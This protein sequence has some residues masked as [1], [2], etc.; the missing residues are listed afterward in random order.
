[1]QKRRTSAPGFTLIEL[2]VVIA[3]IAVLIGLLLPAVQKVREAA[4]R[5]TCQNNLKQ[6]GLA[7]QSYHDTNQMYPPGFDPQDNGPFVKMLPYLEQANQLS[8]YSFRPPGSPA[9]TYA[10]WYADPQNRPPTVTGSTTVPRP[11]ARYGA[12]GNFKTFLCPSAPSPDFYSTV[13]LMHNYDSGAGSTYCPPG[14]C[15]PSGLASGSTTSG[16]PGSMILGRSNYMASAGEF[17]GSVLIRNSNPQAGTQVIGIFG[18]AQGLR[19]S[20]VTD[21]T[22]NTIMFAES[23]GGLSGTSWLGE[24]WA[25]ARWW[26]A[27]GTCPSGSNPPNPNCDKSTL[28]RGLGW[29]LPGSLHTGNAINVCLTD[30]SIRSI[31]S[32]NIDFLTISYLVGIADGQ[33]ETFDW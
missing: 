10:Q 28:G 4:N 6:L 27:F 23:A 7:S 5:M 15:Y 25:H 26:S 30:G 2:L 31:N 22:T 9:P 1:M 12:E 17:R 24:T 21:G 13:I 19:Q 32:A 11:P 16:M 20:R 14:I 3:I 8:L 18:R 29:A 33:V